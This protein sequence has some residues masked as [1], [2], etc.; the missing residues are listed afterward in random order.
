MGASAEGMG[1]TDGRKRGKLYVPAVGL[2]RCD[3]EE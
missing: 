2:S 3:A 1:R